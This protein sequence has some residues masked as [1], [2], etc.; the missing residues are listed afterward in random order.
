VKCARQKSPGTVVEGFVVEKISNVG[1]YSKG[2][3]RNPSFGL[4]TKAKGL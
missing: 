3:C 2:G 4:T 1:F